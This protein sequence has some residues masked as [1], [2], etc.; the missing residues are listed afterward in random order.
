LIIFFVDAFLDGLDHCLN[1]DDVI[2]GD[3]WWRRSV[4]LLLAW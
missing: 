2:D 3:W 1:I 4:L